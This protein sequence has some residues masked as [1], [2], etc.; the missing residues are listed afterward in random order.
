MEYIAGNIVEAVR[1]GGNLKARDK[2]MMG[3]LLAGLSFSHA[4]V[5]SVHCMAEALGEHV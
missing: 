3:S 1:N 2:M 4:D 5:A